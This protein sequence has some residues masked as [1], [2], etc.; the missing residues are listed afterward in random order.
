MPTEAQLPEPAVAL[1]DAAR[2]TVPDW[3]RRVTEDA[4]RRGGVD[5]GSFGD[6]LATAVDGAAGE[7]LDGLAALLATDVDRQRTTPLSILRDAATVATELLRARGVTPSASS[8][9]GHPDDPYDLG[10]ASWADVDASLHEPGLVW[11][12]WKAMTVLARRRDDGLR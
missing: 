12:A 2:A 6:D 3:L 7:A 11:G 10:P 1:L 5:P 8:G 4:C 9:R